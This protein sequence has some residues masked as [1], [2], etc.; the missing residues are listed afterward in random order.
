MFSLM[1][2][3]VYPGHGVAYI[4]RILKKQTG[5][6]VV[7][8]YELAFLNKEMTILVSQACATQ[9]GLRPLATP[10]GVSLWLPLLLEPARRLGSH[11]FTAS[12]WNK[13]NK[14][15]QNKLRRGDFKELLEVYRDLSA[16]AQT[17]NL[18]FGERNLLTKTENLL[19]EELALIEN[20]EPAAALLVLRSYAERT[21]KVMP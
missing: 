16:I 6:G 19:A 14:E 8:F 9:V 13:R 15:Y 12:S 18:S 4:A 1:Q 7:E 21:P 3:V 10:A 17:K 2:K 5:D 20:I 11:E